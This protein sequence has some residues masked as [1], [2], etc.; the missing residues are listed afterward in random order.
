MNHLEKLFVTNDAATIIK[1]L[2]VKYE[3][4][5]ETKDFELALLDQALN[6]QTRILSELI[7]FEVSTNR[8]Q[9]R[10]QDWTLIQVP[11]QQTLFCW[12]PKVLVWWP[13]CGLDFYLFWILK[14][15]KSSSK[16]PHIVYFC[17]CSWKQSVNLHKEG[18]SA[19]NTP[20]FRHTLCRQTQ[21][22]FKWSPDNQSCN[23]YGL[24]VCWWF[25]F[26]PG[27]TSSS[28]DVSSSFTDA[29]TG[30]NKNWV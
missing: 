13:P 21:R 26:S 1:E 2:E 19:L 11:L 7:N 9:T 20:I 30:G 24:C 14:L 5:I 22:T 28:K 18:L 17:F 25:H 6:K 8:W 10:A 15:N 23:K 12:G 3:R 27:S 29:R 16:V 4:I